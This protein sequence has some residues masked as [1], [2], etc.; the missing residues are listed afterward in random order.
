MTPSDDL[1]GRMDLQTAPKEGLM[2]VLIHDGLSCGL[3]ETNKAD[4]SAE[5]AK[6]ITG[7]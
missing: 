3:H 6:T 2:S 4:T 1:R 7:K 5:A